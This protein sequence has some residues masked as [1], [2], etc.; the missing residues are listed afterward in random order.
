MAAQLQTC[1]LVGL[2]L[3][4][5]SSMLNTTI[6]TE[7]MHAQELVALLAESYTGMAAACNLLTEW[8]AILGGQPAAAVSATAVGTVTNLFVS[9]FDAT[10]ADA[11]LRTVRRARTYFVFLNAMMTATI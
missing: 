11:Q 1:G 9:N 3:F 2:C 10:I 6:H 7:I 4:T 5:L 8:H